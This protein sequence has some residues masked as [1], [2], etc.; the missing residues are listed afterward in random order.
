MK[1]IIKEMTATSI[2]INTRTNAGKN[3][4]TSEEEDERESSGGGA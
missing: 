3:P 4:G 1:K 2:R